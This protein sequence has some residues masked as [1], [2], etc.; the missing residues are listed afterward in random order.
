MEEKLRERKAGRA[1]GGA[2]KR[3]SGG[4]AGSQEYI[5][6][7]LMMW[8]YVIDRELS[9]SLSLF[10]CMRKVGEYIDIDCHEARS[11]GP[12]GFPPISYLPAESRNLGGIYR[13]SKT[14][15]NVIEKWWY[16]I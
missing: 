8:Y 15:R 12:E 5:Q 16:M 1:V 4:R 13:V 6:H 14:K 3:L 10:V 7:P 11:R 2:G 9:L